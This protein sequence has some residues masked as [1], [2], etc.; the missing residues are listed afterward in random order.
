MREVRGERA[1]ATVPPDDVVA[2]LWQTTDGVIEA[3]GG[4]EGW[5]AL[6]ADE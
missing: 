2:I 6:P 1:L 5:E 3:A 4:L